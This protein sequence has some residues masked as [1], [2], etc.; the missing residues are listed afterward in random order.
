MAYAAIGGGVV[1]DIGVDPTE[2]KAIISE[3]MTNQEIYFGDSLT[4]KGGASGGSNLYK[5][6]DW[7]FCADCVPQTAMIQNPGEVIFN[8]AGNYEV[9]FTVTDSKGA[10]AT[11]T[12]MISVL[13][14]HPPEANIISPLDDAGYGVDAKIGFEVVAVDPDGDGMEYYW[15]FGND[16]VNLIFDLERDNR[17]ANEIN[18]SVPGTY[19]ANVTVTDK[20]DP[21]MSIV[22][23]VTVNIEEE[24]NLNLLC[25]LA[26][27]ISCPEGEVEVLRI[28]NVTS[29]ISYIDS[30]T[31]ILINTSLPYANAHIAPPLSISSAGENYTPVCC[32]GD[33]YVES[34]GVINEHYAS[35]RLYSDFSGGHITNPSI[36]YL[37]LSLYLKFTGDRAGTICKV[38]TTYRLENYSCKRDDCYVNDD[39]DTSNIPLCPCDADGC[40]FSDSKEFVADNDFYDFK[41]KDVDAIGTLVYTRQLSVP[42]S[43]YSA[44]SNYYKNT[45]SYTCMY[46]YFGLEEGGGE[47]I[48]RCG[49][50]PTEMCCGMP[51]D[52]S[53]NRNDNPHE[54]DFADCVDPVCHGE[55]P[56]ACGL[57]KVEGNYTDGAIYDDDLE[58]WIVPAYYCSSGFDEGV[59]D[60]PA[61]VSSM[62]DPINT[63][64]CCKVGDYWDPDYP[65]GEGSCRDYNP[66]YDLIRSETCKFDISDCE[67]L[68]DEN[69]RSRFRDCMNDYFTD[70]NCLI[71]PEAGSDDAPQACCPTHQYAEDTFAYLDVKVYI[72]P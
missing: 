47:H 70:L 16:T 69:Q 62:H 56:K 40:G 22:K 42:Y 21:R 26:S 50:Y 59:S 58:T 18:Y 61:F 71:M 66:C 4:F 30:D 2:L 27:G 28:S 45:E 34:S 44:C 36:T 35:M 8:K 38:L 72:V 37:P 23:K 19:Y 9:K 15:D 52:C 33:I 67:K 68:K 41:C 63:K 48:A 32:V 57:S 31:G 17:F 6:Y 10:I 53:N 5:F 25:T 43:E 20:G 64:H 12:R 7:E 29:N 49:L 24:L 39:Y 14:N 54:D 46:S 51:E 13:S 1:I 60:L 65:P 3:P 11:A 55:S